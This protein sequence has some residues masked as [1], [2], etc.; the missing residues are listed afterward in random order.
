MLRSILPP[1]Q[2]DRAG[3]RPSEGKRRKG[4]VLV[5]SAIVMILMLGMLA[6]SIDVGYMLKMRSEI[7]RAVDSAALAGVGVLAEGEDLAQAKAVEYLV[8]NPVGSRAAFDEGLM[9]QQIAEFQAEHEDD[10]VVNIGDWEPT[11]NDP[12]TG[13]A[14]RIVPSTGPPSALQVYFKATDQPFFFGRFLG[15]ERFSVEASSI[16]I[17]QPRDIMVVLDLSGSMNDD[18]EFRS[19]DVLGK[20][21][22]ESNLAQCYAD[23]GSPVYGNGKFPLAPAW[24]VVPG[25][26]PTSSRM[27]KIH[28]EYRRD[29]VY[30]TSTK[31]LTSVTLGLSNG[32]EKTFGPLS[33]TSGTF[34]S[35]SSNLSVQQVWVRSGTNGGSGEL[36]DFSSESAIAA[37]VIKA[38]DWGTVAYPSKGSWSDYVAYCCKSSNE[39]ADAGYRYKFGYLNLLHYWLENRESAA[40]TPFLWKMSAQ[41]ITAVKDSVDTFIQFVEEGSSKDRIGLAVYNSTSG[42]GTL[43]EHLTMNFARIQSLTRQ[44]QA[45]HYSSYTN[46]AG[47]MKEGRLELVNNARKGAFK[48]MVLLTDGVANYYNGSVNESAAK[49]AVL[50]EAS[51][52]AAAK[53]KIVTISLGS[54][55]DVQLMQQVA[56]TTGGYHFNIPGGVDDSAYLI[57]LKAAFREIASDRPLQLVK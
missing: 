10:Y 8:R 38:F 35:G 42:D 48:M 30:V 34:S 15:K 3:V 18:T 12:L 40:E 36:F 29:S 52:A 19:I 26:D 43:E 56:D 14:G 51:L 6:F 23:L 55:A 45:G 54:G 1:A 17:Y 20:A 16:A 57:K 44:K 46:I 47:G 2:R 32:T 49:N 7:Q 33:A 27:P 31:A 5:F 11:G 4:A 9:N 41:P 24:V 25:V 13:G 53:L 37:A 28:V 21:Q 22:V 39:N 50:Q